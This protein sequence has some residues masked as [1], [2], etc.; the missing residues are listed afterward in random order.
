MLLVNFMFIIYKLAL[1]NNV[2]LNRCLMSVKIILS[3]SGSLNGPAVGDLGRKCCPL[4]FEQQLAN[5]GQSVL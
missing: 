5:N 4:L 1:I 3:S 2:A